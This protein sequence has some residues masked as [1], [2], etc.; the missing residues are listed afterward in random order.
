MIRWGMCTLSDSA[1]SQSRL[2]NEKLH[3]C[4]DCDRQIPAHIP[5]CIYCKG[6]YKRRGICWYCGELPVK[7]AKPGKQQSQ[8]CAGCQQLAKALIPKVENVRTMAWSGT[9]SR[10]RRYRGVQQSAH[11]PPDED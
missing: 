5:V 11:L 7:P 10:G 1:K 6:A 2:M 9:E 8:Y 4:R 3:K